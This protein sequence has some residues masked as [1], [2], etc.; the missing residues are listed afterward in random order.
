MIDEKIAESPTKYVSFHFGDHEDASKGA[1][2]PKE[3][4]NQLTSIVSKLYREQGLKLKITY[5]E[6]VVPN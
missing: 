1:S 2:M 3:V 5:T 6:V 4:F